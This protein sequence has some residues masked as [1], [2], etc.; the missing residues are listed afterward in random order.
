MYR[1]L[2]SNAEVIE[3]VVARRLS[4]SLTRSQAQAHV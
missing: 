4:Y 1:D 2:N 3:V